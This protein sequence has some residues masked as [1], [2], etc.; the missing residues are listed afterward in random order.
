[1]WGRSSVGAILLHIFSR[2]SVHISPD[3]DGVNTPPVIDYRAFTNP[4]DLDLNVELLK[5]VRY[6][7]GHKAMVD[8]LSPIETS[9]GVSGDEQIKAWIRRNINPSVAHQVGT[10][11]LGP[12]ELGGVVG[13]D[14]R[15]H[16]TRKL[17]VA[18][19]SIMPLVPGSH[20]SA[21]AYAI[22]EKVQIVTLEYSF[23]WIK[24]NYV[25]GS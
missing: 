17:S 8:A 1:M 3:D 11:S 25:A 5:G 21:T 14:L 22:G 13:P 7:M 18:D 9:P 20:T 4:V 15:V 23:Q 16:G 6:L 24:A 2:G 12:I 19:N 10:A